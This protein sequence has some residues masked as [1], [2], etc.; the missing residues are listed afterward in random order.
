MDLPLQRTLRDLHVVASEYMAHLGSKVSSDTLTH[1]AYLLLT[2]QIMSQILT[3]LLQNSHSFWTAARNRSLDTAQL[4]RP[5]PPAL[6]REAATRTDADFWNSPAVEPWYWPLYVRLLLLGSTQPVSKRRKSGDTVKVKH[7]GTL[8]AMRLRINVVNK[9]VRR[10][11]GLLTEA[12]ETKP[13]LLK[14]TVFKALILRLQWLARKTD[15]TPHADPGLVLAR[16]FHQHQFAGDPGAM[17]T[18]IARTMQKELSRIG[19]RYGAR[20]QNALTLAA[21]HAGITNAQK[22]A[23]TD[24]MTELSSFGGGVIDTQTFILTQL[25]MLETLDTVLQRLRESTEEEASFERLLK[26]NPDLDQKDFLL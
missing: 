2:M 7:P 24:D 6:M 3:A 12:V 8:L 20:V 11:L 4:L 25:R 23:Y 18:H 13:G 14:H 15:D 10:L 21:M 9:M 16:D 17:P 26:R 5:P 22:F 1:V 19:E